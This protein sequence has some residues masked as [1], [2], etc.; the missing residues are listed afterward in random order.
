MVARDYT[1]RLI[2]IGDFIFTDHT[3][4]PIIG[5]VL[6]ISQ[7]EYFYEPVLLVDCIDR[8]KDRNEH[9]TWLN[10]KKPQTF[11]AR[12]VLIIHQCDI[13][14]FHLSKFDEMFNKFETENIPTKFTTL[15][16]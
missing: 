4:R 10:R 16:S 1:G 3:P 8:F 14:E 7:D 2:N 12:K 13:P 9:Y 5:R 11:K 15:N 6:K